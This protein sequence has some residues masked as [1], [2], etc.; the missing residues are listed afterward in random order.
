[1]KARII[2]LLIAITALLGSATAQETVQ[3]RVMNL[4]QGGEVIQ[5]YNVGDVDSIKFELKF[6]KYRIKNVASG[7][8]MNAA[9]YNSH[10][11][12]T[13][14]GVN[15]T[16]YAESDD[17]IFTFTKSGSNY[18]L[19]TLSGYNIVCQSWNVDALKT[20]GTALTFVDNGDGTYCIKRGSNYFKVEL[21]NG[22]YYPYCDAGYS[23]RAT[24]KLEEVGANNA[25]G[26]AASDYTVSVSSTAGGTAKATLNSLLQ[27]ASLTLSATPQEGY[28]FVNWTK[29]GE[30]VSIDATLYDVIEENVEYKANFRIQSTKLALVAEEFSMQD[31][32]SSSISDNIIDGKYNTCYRSYSTQKNG[33]TAAVTLEKFLNVEYVN[34]YFRYDD[35]P[36]KA[37]I[38][39]STD[40]AVW[41]DV[42]G[43]EFVGAEAIDA[44]SAISY[45]KL[46]TVNCFGVLAKYVRMFVT[47]AKANK[48]L[49]ISEFEVY[50]ECLST[51]TEA[52]HLYVDLGLPSGI[53]WA[54]CNVGATTPEEYGDYFGWG[55]TEP[56]DYYDWGGYKYCNGTY[57][58]MTKYCTKSSYGTVDNKTTLELSDDAAQVNWGGKWRMPTKAEIDELRDTFYCTWTWTTQNGVNGYK[59]T[60]KKNGNSIF[61]PAAGYRQLGGL[62]DAGSDGYYWSTLLNQS[63]NDYA[64]LLYFDSGIVD[65]Y[66][67]S[68][69]GGLSVRAVCE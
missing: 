16:D 69:Y 52:G 1:M 49:T 64:N 23:Q 32:G 34:I 31:A 63:E 14:G 26:D 47:E 59:V 13:V 25:G 17:Q 48:Y 7:K 45:A 3:K 33:A 28:E 6:P 55:E 43:S 51:G 38:Q 44:T 67:H 39:V 66:F 4:Y 18:I 9:N 54:T 27:G 19:T 42:E 57:K 50:G 5:E 29:N 12:G 60:S 53:K 10:A 24:W 62:Y 61:L 58:T 40:G 36:T 68:R 41:T 30:G 37:K 65:I 20:S 35:L 56:K 2:T 46:I 21:V 15:C 8:Y 22:T 11:D